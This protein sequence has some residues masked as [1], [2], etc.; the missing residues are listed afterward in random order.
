MPGMT[1]PRGSLPI[2]SGSRR[3]WLPACC[4]A[5]ALLFLLIAHVAAHSAHAQSGSGLSDLEAQWHL[6]LGLAYEGAGDWDAAVEQY[7]IAAQAQSAPLAREAT[8][9][10][11]NLL[12]QKN[13]LGPRLVKGLS[14]AVVWA[15]A[16][17]LKV[18]IVLL[19][20]YGVLRALF[21]FSRS[22]ARWTILPFSDLT[23]AGL[24]MA[25]SESIVDILHEAHLTYR[26]GTH[27]VLSASEEV[28]LPSLLAPATG[29]RLL[30][31]L[32]TMSQVEIS[33]VGLP[34][35]SV[36]TA[37]G[38]WFE[39][40]RPHIRGTLQERGDCLC[41]SA[42]LREKRSAPA[43]RVWTASRSA[44][45]ETYGACLYEIERDLAY[46]I[47]Y[48]SQK[49]WQ[50]RTPR[51]L[52]LFAEALQLMQRFQERPTSST[53]DLPRA[54][55][56]LEKAVA[57]EPRYAAAQYNL[58]VVYH[59]LGLHAKSIDV[60]KDLR[61]Q[62][63]RGLEQEIAYS[64]GIAYYHLLVPWAYDLAEREFA[65]V[66]Q[67]P[68]E[69]EP[70]GA[71][72]V[73]RALAHCGLASVYA[74]RM[75]LDPKNAES[76]LKKARG[77]FEQALGLGSD[78]PQVV[79]A[80]HTAMGMA[81]LNH[82][83]A[84]AAAGEF[85]QAVRA[86]PDYWRAYVHWGRAEMAQK[87]FDHA[88]GALQQAVV[89][90]PGYEF[91]HYQ[92]GVALKRAAR[93]AEAAQALARA[94]TIAQAHDERGSVLAESRQDYAAALAEFE[95]ALRLNPELSN[96]MVNIAWY[97]LE[98]GYT[99]A[100]HLGRAQDCAQRALVL[101]K[102]SPNAWH[103]HCILGRVYLEI[104]RLP[105]ALG[106]LNRAK[107]LR[108]GAD[109]VHFFLG[110]TYLRMGELGKAKQ[111]FQTFLELP[112]SSTWHKKAHG[113]ALDKIAWIEAEQ[114][115]AATKAAGGGANDVDREQ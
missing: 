88:V 34:V 31:S 11:E 38:R 32:G 3:R 101:D 16:L 48:D 33:G 95:Q 50:A 49:G 8:R 62:P 93:P 97:T 91:A 84:A 24:G 7:R 112:G 43:S 52:Q 17:A 42:Q 64:L 105:D 109:Q 47:L 26:K 12:R 106:E 6:S 111:A 53:A 113:L 72:R 86:K 80:A 57:L 36:F 9:R 30:Q 85:E 27:G 59:N 70:E 19:M 41:L 35:G 73:L 77:H 40:G 82:G 44:T 92:L 37:L 4:A 51:T 25:V 115:T 89:L 39:M 75:H 108:A 79:A 55:E 18:L 46:E 90:N 5:L 67:A 2:V 10:L 56:L 102:D 20:A 76:H 15:V 66:V 100:E 81:L 83:D 22:R 98:A 68:S 63:D 99:D 74:Q 14:D 13:R 87:R 107:S 69:P 103:R 96:A 29:E 60:L 65:T 110:E 1:S 104:G 114:R 61:L 58:A 28:D 45:S 21:H 71:N 23:G 54:A 78:E 94:P